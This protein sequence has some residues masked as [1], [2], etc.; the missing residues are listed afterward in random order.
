MAHEL[1]QKFLV[2]WVIDN[3]LHNDY[4]DDYDEMRSEAVSDSIKGKAIDTCILL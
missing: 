1:R 2:N 3:K 4:M